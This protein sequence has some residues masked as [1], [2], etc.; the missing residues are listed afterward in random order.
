MRTSW[1]S[2]YKGKLI[3]DSI[4]YNDECFILQRNAYNNVV[5]IVSG[6]EVLS[7][8]MQAFSQMTITIMVCGVPHHEML[9]VGMYLA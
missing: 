9:S 7:T 4:R 6:H 3:F 5:F 1:G 2:K 8:G